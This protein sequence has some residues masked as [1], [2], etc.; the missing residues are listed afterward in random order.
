MLTLTFTVCARRR[1]VP[2]RRRRPHQN[3]L[4][5]GFNP[6][7]LLVSRHRPRVLS[8]S[9]FSRVRH[10][11]GRC[12]RGGSRR[13]ARA[14]PRGCTARF[15][16]MRERLAVLMYHDIA[17]ASMVDA[18]GM[19]GPL[20]ARYKLD[21]PA[22]DAHLAAIAETGRRVGVTVVDGSGVEVVLTFDDGG[23]SAMHA[24]DLLEERGWRGHFFVTT[25]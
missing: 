3:A 11:P 12:A 21:P 15:V 23:A 2:L 4:S 7:E 20:A 19:T 17:A 14:T 25:G 10:P 18:V 16:R 5:H 13:K 9:Q 6:R 22:F 24:A 1:S 8:W